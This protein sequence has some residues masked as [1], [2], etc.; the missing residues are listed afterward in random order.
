MDHMRVS[1]IVHLW[2]LET[3]PELSLTRLVR[4]LS[5][6]PPRLLLSSVR[7]SACPPSLRTSTTPRRMPPRVFSLPPRRLLHCP[8]LQPPACR[9]QLLSRKPP[10]PTLAS[11]ARPTQRSPPHSP[12]SPHSSRCYARRRFPRTSLRSYGFKASTTGR[13][14]SLWRIPFRSFAKPPK[15]PSVS[16][17]RRGLSIV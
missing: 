1:F 4:K 3:S 12:S 16:T 10:G 2:W 6:L 13:H 7:S 11:A 14:S 5:L 17:L 8:P 15:T 9:P